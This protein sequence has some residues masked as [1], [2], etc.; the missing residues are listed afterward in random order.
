MAGKFTINK[1]K[2]DGD[3]SLGDKASIIENKKNFDLRH[4]PVDKIVPNPSNFYELSNIEDLANNIREFG[5]MQ[6]LEVTEF[7]DGDERKYRIITGHRRYEAIKL[8]IANGENIETIPCKIERDLSDI[9]ER[10]RLI[11]SNSDTRELTQED[12]RK[13][14]E[15]LQS[16]YSQKATLTGEKISKTEI[17]EAIAQTVGLS[18]KQV[19]R[20]STINENLIPELQEYFDTQKISFGQ[21]VEFARLEPDMQNTILALLK[22][23]DKVTSEEFNIIKAENKKLVDEGKSK[24]DLIKEQTK[25]IE[26]KQ[27]IIKTILD[28]KKSLEDDLSKNKLELEVAVEE[29]SSLEERIREEVA[30]LTEEEINNLKDR[31]KETEEKV[32]S[33]K[34]KEEELE[35]KLKETESELIAKT[36]ELETKTRE[37]EPETKI[38]A[39]IKIDK[40]TLE[41]A[42]AEEKIKDLRKTILENITQILNISKKYDIGVVADV[43]SEI[44]ESIKQLVD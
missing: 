24:D 2:T 1:L 32:T 11:K 29:K 26:A 41:K 9:E 38:N 31:L 4:I 7:M 35:I 34:A 43:Y 39:E 15:E 10:L 21:A 27:K 37:T 22:E 6:N 23:K 44:S 19:E 33:F 36:E 25:E 20:Y 8:L 12:K 18:P 5:L 14:V 28:E 40:D 17:K 30:T 13:Q 3:R 16:L 42:V